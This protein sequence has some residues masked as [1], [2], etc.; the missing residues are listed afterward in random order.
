MEYNK[1]KVIVQEFDSSD[2]FLFIISYLRLDKIN[3]T[4]N[5]LATRR[6]KRWNLFIII[7]SHLK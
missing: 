1:S 4:F 7:G 5:I 2:V 6:R 3:N